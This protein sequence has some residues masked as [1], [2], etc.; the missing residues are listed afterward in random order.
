MSFKKKSTKKLSKQERKRNKS[1]Q[2]PTE[3][4]KM[5]QIKEEIQ[6]E[7]I[8]LNVTTICW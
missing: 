2:W 8:V 6:K 1:K 4:E 5:N 7:W 3:E